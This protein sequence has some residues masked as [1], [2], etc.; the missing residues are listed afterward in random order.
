MTF[1]ASG[2]RHQA[3]ETTRKIDD[4][5]AVHRR[6]KQVC[7]ANHVQGVALRLADELIARPIVTANWVQRQYDVSYPTANN[8]V[9]RLEQ[10]GLLRQFSRGSDGRLFSADEVMQ[11]LER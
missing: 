1:F 10:L 9:A 6:T 7:H 8:A 11:I 3:D 2:L 5:V 4:L